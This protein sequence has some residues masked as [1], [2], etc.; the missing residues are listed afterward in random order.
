MQ[1]FD[2]GYYSASEA[3]ER[4]SLG[5]YTAIGLVVTF[6]A[7]WFAIQSGLLYSL[8]AANPALLYVFIIAELLVVIWLSARIQKLSVGAA[9]ALFFFYAILN[10]L[11]LSVI[12]LVYEMASAILLF[13]VTAG[14]FGIM[15]AWGYATKQDLSSWRKILV[16]GLLGLALF[17][18]LSLFINLT[19]LETAVCYI[20]VLLFLGMTAYDTQK[21]KTYYYALQSDPAMLKKASIISALSLYLDFINLFLYLLR[22]FGRRR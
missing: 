6:A 20:G 14:V 2:K 16:F 15:A 3:E 1:E 17:W 11:T 9:T 8:L 22:L 10:G 21:I 13:A 5:R 19:F 4:M 7:S 12:F 18:L